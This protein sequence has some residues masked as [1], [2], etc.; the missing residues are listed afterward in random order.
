MQG[1]NRPHP[2]HAAAASLSRAPT[3]ALLRSDII[4]Y[5]VKRGS[6]R[7]SLTSTAKRT[8]R[9][10]VNRSGFN[11]AQHGACLDEGGGGGREG[12]VH[13][14]SHRATHS[15]RHGGAGGGA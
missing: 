7:G 12:D 1:G 5:A 4:V 9:R 2:C 10:V 6:V 11:G 3:P 15:S 14:L 13:L 8:S